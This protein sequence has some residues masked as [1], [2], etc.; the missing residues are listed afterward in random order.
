[1]T[2]DARLVVNAGLAVFR[3]ST[4]QPYDRGVESEYMPGSR[5][6]ASRRHKQLCEKIFSLF[7][8]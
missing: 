6:Y 8:F 2:Y 1:M 3:H 5:D 7:Q 4:N